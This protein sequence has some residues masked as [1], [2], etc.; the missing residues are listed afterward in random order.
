LAFLQESCTASQATLYGEG[1][2]APLTFPT[3][4]VML[5]PRHLLRSNAMIRT[6][7]EFRVE[8]EYE[9]NEV[10]AVYIMG[11]DGYPKVDVLYCM[12]KLEIQQAALA[13]IARDAGP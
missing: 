9:E 6:F 11:T 2:R 13:A 8:I 3:P 5:V 4:N 7:L 12:T 1:Q 10:I